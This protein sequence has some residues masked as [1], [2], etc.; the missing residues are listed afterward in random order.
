VAA[1]PV[2]PHVV[3]HLPIY[4]LRRQV[5]EPS[6]TQGDEPEIPIS[7]GVES[8]EDLQE[9]LAHAAAAAG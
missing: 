7:V 1:V 2:Q 6:K 9:D 4:V 3:P 8:V 5:P